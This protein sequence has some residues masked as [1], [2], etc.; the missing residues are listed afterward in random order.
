MCGA[1]IKRYE[2]WATAETP[3]ALVIL[4]SFSGVGAL[5]RIYFLEE[6]RILRDGMYCLNN[7]GTA[8]AHALEPVSFYRSR[9][10]KIKGRH[11]ASRQ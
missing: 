3:S 5:R 1:R 4:A 2:N 9:E 8:R 10:L 7:S 6:T 11:V